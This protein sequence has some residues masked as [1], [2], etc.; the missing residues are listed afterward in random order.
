M[1]F[2]MALVLCHLMASVFILGHLFILQ[3][4]PNVAKFPRMGVLNFLGLI[5]WGCRFSGDA[6]FPVQRMHY[7]YF[8]YCQH[9]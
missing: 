6:N 7:T 5:E 9:I 4:M 3:G 8:Q 1:P 2:I